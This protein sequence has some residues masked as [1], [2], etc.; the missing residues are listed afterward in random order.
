MLENKPGDL[1]GN[2][3]VTMKGSSTDTK[4]QFT[5]TIG[6]GTNISF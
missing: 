1:H 2:V 5:K 3:L 6:C 4:A